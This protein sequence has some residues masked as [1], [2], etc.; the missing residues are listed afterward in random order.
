[1]NEARALLAYMIDA[2]SVGLR[3]EKNWEK[4]KRENIG[5]LGL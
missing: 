1:M 2:V 4:K 5:G 3:V